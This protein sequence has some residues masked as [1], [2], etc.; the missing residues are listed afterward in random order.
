[1][2]LVVRYFQLSARERSL[3]QHAFFFVLVIRLALW[4]I[5]FRV[6]RSWVERLRKPADSLP[7]MHPNGIREV[8]WAVEAAGRRIPGATCLTQGLATQVLLGQRGEPSQ[9]CLGVAL[10]A[11][12]R[13]EAHAWV[14]TRGRV[15]IGGAVERFG[16]FA[17]LEHLIS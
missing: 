6:T 5:P 15:V 10:S 8:A 11:N 1:M 4:T 13:L 12:G 3:L 16:R 9:L 14:E 2:R 17:R 7:A